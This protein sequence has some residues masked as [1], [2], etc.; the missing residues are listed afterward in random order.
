[1]STW[2]GSIPANSDQSKAC[3]P[4]RPRPEG[5]HSGDNLQKHSQRFKRSLV[6]GQPEGKSRTILGDVTGSRYDE[7]D[8]VIESCADDACSCSVQVLREGKI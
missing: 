7:D 1:M 3:T 2:L 4:V 8:H 6:I 5:G